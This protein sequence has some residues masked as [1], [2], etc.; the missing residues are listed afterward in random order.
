MFGANVSHV[1][2]K[3]WGNLQGKVGGKF[4]CAL[5]GKFCRPVFVFGLFVFNA[6]F[7][8]LVDQSIRTSNRS[9]TVIK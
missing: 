1:I 2:C 6:T 9:P 3:I 8:V 7:Q 4:K 5:D